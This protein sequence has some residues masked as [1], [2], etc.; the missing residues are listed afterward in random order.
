[1]VRALIT[2]LAGGEVDEVRRDAIGVASIARVVTADL[3]R[4]VL[5]DIDPR[6]TFEWLAERT[7]AE[8]LGGGLTLHELVRR[9][10]RADLRHRDPERERELRRRIADHLYARAAAGNTLL[11]V[12]LAELVDSDAIRAFYGWEGATRNRI[13]GVRDAGQGA[14]GA[15]AGLGRLRRAGGSTPGALIE[16]APERVVVRPRRGR[17]P[18]RLL[19]GGHARHRA[20][21]RPTRT[22]SWARGWPTPREHVP[23]GNV[24]LWRDSFDFTD[25]PTSGIQGMLNMVWVLRSGL[26]NPRIAYLPI[27]PRVPGATVFSEALG[28]QH[29]SELDV[30]VGDAE[31]QCH[32]I[33][34][35]EGG[36]LGLQRAFVYM[37]LGLPAP[38]PRDPGGRHRARP[39]SVGARRGARRAAQPGGAGRP[40][41]Q[42]AGHG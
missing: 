9:A 31:F 6:E 27:D 36:L 38:E 30:H 17:Q 1:M 35:G 19:D 7:F 18:V 39:V 37:E 10:A 23:D 15:A 16:Q 32:V 28:G 5:P 14:A 26:A 2:Q 29:V 11:T 40:G 3:L 12:D 42:P 21:R 8:S 22:S 34:Y 41:A 25:D 33:D 4:E 13:D 20:R 24:I